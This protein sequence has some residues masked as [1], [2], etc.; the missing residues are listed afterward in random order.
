MQ[1][2]QAFELWSA[3]QIE[4]F[5]KNKSK[6]YLGFCFGTLLDIGYSSP[7]FVTGYRNVM[8]LALTRGF[9]QLYDNLTDE[10]KHID[11]YE[12]DEPKNSEEKKKPRE[13]YCFIIP[14][15]W[16]KRKKDVHKAKTIEKEPILL[17]IP[18]KRM[19]YDEAYIGSNAR[20]IIIRVPRPPAFLLFIGILFGAIT[21]SFGFMYYS[22]EEVLSHPSDHFRAIGPI[23]ESA[24][25]IIRRIK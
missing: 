19:P 4:L 18:R 16:F 21:V 23:I 7:N 13:N 6:M 25:Q 3:K 17:Q 12:D 24:G 22:S 1:L 14:K 8:L 9:I 2:R 20:G 5:V 10:N 15:I 11:P